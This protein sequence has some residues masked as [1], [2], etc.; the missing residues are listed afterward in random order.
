MTRKLSKQFSQFTDKTSIIVNNRETEIQRCAV[1]H[2]ILVRATDLATD[3]PGTS[4]DGTLGGFYCKIS[5]GKMK[6]RSKVVPETPNPNWN[7][8]FNFDLYSD[9]QS[10]SDQLMFI[11]NELTISLRSKRGLT[12]PCGGEQ[13]YIVTIDLNSLELEKTHR[14]YKSFTSHPDG[15]PLQ[16]QLYTL[17]T[18]TGTTSEHSETNLNFIEDKLER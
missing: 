5:L 8:E 2:M 4:L 10:D 17:L 15:I 1:L 16:S 14:V 11:E 6:E 12:G 3:L 9:Q 7:E 13:E 18:I